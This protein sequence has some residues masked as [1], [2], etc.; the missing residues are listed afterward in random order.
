L[1]KRKQAHRTS[2]PNRI[3]A[4]AV[5]PLEQRMMMY[6]ATVGVNTGTTFQTVD[7][8]GAAMMTWTT[9]NEYKNASFYD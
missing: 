5:E 6:S 2:L 4:S 7:G 1:R 3:R 8:F 9:P